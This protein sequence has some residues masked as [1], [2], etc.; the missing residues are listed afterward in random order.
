MKLFKYALLLVV[1]IGFVSVASADITS[2]YISSGIHDST[3]TS[4]YVYGGSMEVTATST[5]ALQMQFKWYKPGAT[6]P[7]RTT[8]TT[9]VPFTSIY[10][11]VNVVGN[12][13]VVVTDVDHIAETKTLYFWVQAPNNYIYSINGKD[14]GLGALVVSNQVEVIVTPYLTNGR[15]MTFEWVSPSGSIA[16]TTLSVPKVD[17][18]YTDVLDATKFDTAGLWNIRVYEYA[19]NTQIG[20]GVEEFDGSLPEFPIG[21]FI[22]LLLAGVVYIKVRKDMEGS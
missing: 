10:T 14:D 2:F 1:L 18:K 16:Q 3:N 19:G 15:K 5:E 20:S 12:W 9:T 22:P 6:N 17:G 4:A 8:T 7:S 11:N 21:S 13:R